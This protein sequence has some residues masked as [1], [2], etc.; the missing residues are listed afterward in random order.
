MKESDHQPITKVEKTEHP[1]EHKIVQNITDLI[2]SIG[3]YVDERQIAEEDLE[4]LVQLTDS[5]ISDL[6]YEDLTQKI[7]HNLEQEKI[8]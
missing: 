1:Q 4:Y 6:K 7:K 3:E 2:T 5:V 8:N